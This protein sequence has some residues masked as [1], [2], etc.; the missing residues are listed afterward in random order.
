FAILLPKI[1]NCDDIKASL[2][3]REQ[4]EERMKKDKA[5]EQ[6]ST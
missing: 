2:L 6:P 4:Y 3:T 5:V 1:E